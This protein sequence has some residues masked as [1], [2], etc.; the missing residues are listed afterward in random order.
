MCAAMSVVVVWRERRRDFAIVLPVLVGGVGE[1]VVVA[2]PSL[3]QNVGKCLAKLGEVSIA[4][5]I[6]R[7]EMVRARER[8]SDT[9]KGILDGV[10]EEELE[11]VS[12]LDALWVDLGVVLE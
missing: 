11:A 7:Q 1:V 3:A 5:S 9:G 10:V 12:V 2:R 8:N 4:R 6:C